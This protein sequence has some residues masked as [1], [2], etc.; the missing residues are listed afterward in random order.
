MTAELVLLLSV[1]AFCVI[2][3]FFGDKGFVNN[4]NNNLPYLSARVEKHVA[5]GQGFWANPERPTKWS[6]GEK[7]TK[8]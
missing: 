4:F 5:V 8:N 3:L 7:D 6:P 1:Y 2:G